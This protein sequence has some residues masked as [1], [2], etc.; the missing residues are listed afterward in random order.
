MI[1]RETRLWRVGR[2]LVNRIF[3]LQLVVVEM[4][5]LVFWSRVFRVRD[6]RG[7]CSRLMGRV[8]RKLGWKD[9]IVWLGCRVLTLKKL[10]VE[11]V[12]IEE[13]EERLTE[14]RNSL[15]LFLAVMQYSAKMFENGL[16]LAVQHWPLDRIL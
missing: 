14:L 13:K 4:R 2:G 3:G 6:G 11:A 8:G 16:P 9:G 5:V 12:K 1:W 7:L 10:I 15:A